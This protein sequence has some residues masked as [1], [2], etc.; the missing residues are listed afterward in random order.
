MQFFTQIGIDWRLLIAQIINFGILLWLLNKFLYK[1]VVK[2][3]QEDE[4]KRREVDEAKESLEQEKEQVKQEALRELTRAKETSRK[5]IADAARLAEELK[6]QTSSEQRKLSEKFMEH[7]QQETESLSVL[8]REKITREEREVMMQSVVRELDKTLDDVRKEALEK[9]FFD[10]MI[11][12]LQKTRFLKKQYTL[13]IRL[14]YAFT[15]S[16]EDVVLLEEILCK[17]LHSDE[18]HIEMKRNPKLISGVNLQ[19]AGMYF[20]HNIAEMFEKK[21][22]QQ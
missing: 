21:G 9:M 2:Q 5:I 16:K 1:P 4:R 6:N 15:L 17:K 18:V 19:V 22:I 12:A 3:I 20:S 13:P 7:V 11:V 10:R 8:L 14:E